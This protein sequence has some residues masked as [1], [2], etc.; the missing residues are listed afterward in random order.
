MTSHRAH[1]LN[2][3][4]GSF[5]VSNEG[6]VQ[7]SYGS[8][9]SSTSPGSKNLAKPKV[10]QNQ[11]PFSANRYTGS[12]LVNNAP[13]PIKTIEA[14]VLEREIKIDS[15]NKNLSSGMSKHNIVSNRNSWWKKTEPGS[16]STKDRSLRMMKK[17]DPEQPHWAT[18]QNLKSKFNLMTS[19]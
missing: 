1:E 7:K 4:K 9:Q 19:K 10:S 17:E 5:D 15:G 18:R 8:R 6:N 12:K 2:I 14:K 11:R 16:A 3:R 13:K